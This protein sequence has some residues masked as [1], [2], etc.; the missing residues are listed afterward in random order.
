MTAMFLTRENKKKSIGFAVLVLVLSLFLFGSSALAGTFQIIGI[1][2]GTKQVTILNK[3]TGQQQVI[4]HGDSIQSWRNS[5]VSP[6]YV[7]FSQLSPKNTIVA[8]KV[9]LFNGTSHVF[10]LP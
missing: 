6:D 8:T 9:P 1:D 4:A 2:T 5:D 10:E 3:D 7:L